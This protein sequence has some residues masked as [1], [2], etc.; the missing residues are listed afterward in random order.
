MRDKQ[1]LIITRGLPASGKST[2]AK[3]WVLEDPKTRVR[4]NRDDI[5]KLLGPYWVPTR[6]KLVTAIEDDMIHAALLFGYDTVVDATN[7]KLTDRFSNIRDQV[8]TSNEVTITIEV[9]D[10]TNVP[11]ET[12][13]ERDR[14]RTGDD[15]VGEIV[16]RGMYNKILNKQNI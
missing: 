3:A 5:R 14:Q 7:L 6:E 13:I 2:W 10:F 16:I 8:A 9:K 11:L 15:K 12:C 1:Q 4:V